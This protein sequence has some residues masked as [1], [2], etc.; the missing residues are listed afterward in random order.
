MDFSDSPLKARFRCISAIAISKQATVVHR[1]DADRNKDE[2]EI[3][4]KFS[5]LI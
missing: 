4:A 3:D 2:D 5:K 1:A